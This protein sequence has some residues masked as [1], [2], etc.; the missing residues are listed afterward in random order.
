MYEI[1]RTI[2]FSD[3]DGLYRTMAHSLSY[4]KTSKNMQ[5]YLDSALELLGDKVIVNEGQVK[6]NQ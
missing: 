3:K 4:V 6:L 2:L 1:L 5:E